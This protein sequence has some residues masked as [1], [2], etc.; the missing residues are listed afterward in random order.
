M[1]SA[2]MCMRRI[3]LALALLLAQPA[4]AAELE[5]RVKSAFLLNFARFISLE[6]ERAA[7]A[8]APYEICVLTPDV[9]LD[10]LDG[11]LK[12]KSVRGRP[13]IV[14]RS[15]R[16]ELLRDCHIVYL[17]RRAPDI[18]Q[19]QLAKL[20]GFGVITVHEADSAQSQGVLRLFTEG[21]RQRFEVNLAAIEREKLQASSGLLEI[22]ARV[23]Q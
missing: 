8:N 12:G 21:N 20:A 13:V 9:L 2:S 5:A 10:T 23:R 16:P 14:R 4:Q 11:S 17:S 6:T 3:A 18:L 19:A 1:D 15:D 7:G 22:A